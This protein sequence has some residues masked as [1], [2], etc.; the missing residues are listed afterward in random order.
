M[1]KVLSI[2]IAAYNSADYIRKA[3]DSLLL[4]EIV[5]KIEIFVVDDGGTDQT[6]DIAKE[7][8]V[9]YPDTVFPVHKENGGYGS[10]INTSVSLAT[11]K[12]FKQLDGDDWFDSENLCEFISILESTDADAV[13]TPVTCFY[14]KDSSKEIKEHMKDY[15]SRVYHFSEIDYS[16]II[17]MHE[18]TFKTS[19]LQDMKLQITE[20]CFYTDTELV[21][22]PFPYLDTF[23]TYNKPIYVYRIGREGQ[24]V[25]PEGIRKH[26]KEHEKVFWNLTELYK[27]LQ[28]KS[29]KRILLARLRHEVAQHMKFICIMDKSPEMKQELISFANNVKHKCPELYR[30]SVKY[31]KFVKLLVATNFIAYPFARKKALK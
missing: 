5:D 23:I 15:H 1:K 31:S 10:V 13:Y 24:S 8:A 14:E 16:G 29:K 27:N 26:Y 2:S 3:L 30:E 11:G 19:I 4:P 6:L 28:D 9:K 21:Y 7:Y 20:H 25:S 17:S 18:T 22:K 12:Y